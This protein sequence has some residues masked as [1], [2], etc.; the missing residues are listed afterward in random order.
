MVPS[1][2]PSVIP[3]STARPSIWW[4]TGEW[5][6]SS[7]SRRNTRPGR[8]H[9][10]RRRLRLHRA[11]LY[12]R[13]VGA[14]HHALGLAEPDVER[15]LHRPGRVAGREVERLEVV[16]V[17]LDLGAL[18]H[19]VAQPD[20]DVFQLPPDQRDGM[21]VA[22]HVLTRAEREVEA[23]AGGRDRGRLGVE[24]LPARRATP[25]PMQR[26]GRDGFADDARV[27]IRRPI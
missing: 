3:S 24:H 1:R 20:E 17:A 7:V 4:N 6:A 15:V 18:R 8:D 5:R 23:I 11:H 27:L 25:T 22:A 14:E 26:R 19:L 12:R 13:R 16:P 9:V 2:S 10:D 21:A